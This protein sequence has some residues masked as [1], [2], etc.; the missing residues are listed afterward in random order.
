MMLFWIITAAMILVALALL[1]P[2]LL[3]NRQSNT[4]D[5]DQQNVV[6]AR[7]R[8]VELESE[9]DRGSLSQEQFEQARNELERSLLQDLDQTVEEHAVAAPSGKGG[10]WL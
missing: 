2:S 9:R 10:R 3:R 4:L 8:L 6:I 5:R 7:E 1:A